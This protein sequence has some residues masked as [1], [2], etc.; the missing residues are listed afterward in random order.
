MAILL[1]VCFL[2]SDLIWIIVQSVTGIGTLAVAFAT[3]RNTDTLR[4]L[5]KSNDILLKRYELEKQL[6]IRARMPV[7]IIKSKKSST[8]FFNLVIKN[9]GLHAFQFKLGDIRVTNEDK[10]D[11][12]IKELP[13]DVPAG[14]EVDF[15]IF[16]TVTKPIENVDF[17][18]YFMGLESFERFQHIQKLI[19]E[20][21]KISLP[22]DELGINETPEW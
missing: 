5:V 2:T 19:N 16:H 7:F 18:I 22:I 21:F 8:P 9:V 17:K 13:K 10:Y 3:F 14:G 11:I 1:H 12:E 4:Q 20:D 6:S 15:K